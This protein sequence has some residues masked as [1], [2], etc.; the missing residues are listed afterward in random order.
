MESN[1]SRYR[2]SKAT[3]PL[4]HERG[5]LQIIGKSYGRIRHYKGMKDGKPQFNYHV[6]DINEANRLLALAREVDNRT[7]KIEIPRPIL[8]TIGKTDKSE[9][10]EKALE[11][12]KNCGRSLVWSRT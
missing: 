1:V 6:I 9:I 8:T 5:Y 11:S 10:I 7:S 4:C 3:C 12:E 2:C